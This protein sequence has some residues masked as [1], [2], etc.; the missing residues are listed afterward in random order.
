MFNFIYLSN[1]MTP[2]NFYV[3]N[4]K[5]KSYKTIGGVK[6]LVIKKTETS[7]IYIPSP[8]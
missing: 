4:F 5:I 3:I 7:C 8:V 2:S 1:K 6:E